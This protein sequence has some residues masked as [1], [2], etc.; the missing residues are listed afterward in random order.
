M[1]FNF[2]FHPGP[3]SR[4]RGPT[5]VAYFLDSE[6]HIMR[7]MCDGHSSERIAPST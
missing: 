2:T 3:V 7:S 6:I 1:K 5:I 4:F